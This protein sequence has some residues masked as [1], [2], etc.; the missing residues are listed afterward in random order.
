MQRA[1]QFAALYVK[2]GV[3]GADIVLI[4]LDHGI[5]AHAA[6]VGTM[7]MGAVP[8]FMPSPSVKQDAALYWRQHRDVFGHAQPRAILVSDALAGPVSDA[9]EGTGAAILPVSAV[10]GEAPAEIGELP[11]E[12]AVALLQHSSGTTG[13]KKGVKLSYRAIVAQLDAYRRA[14]NLD[15]VREP[16]IASWL[17]L[18]HDMGLISSFM[19]PLWQG[20]PIL[21]IDP[22]EWTR[23]P[24]LL[25]EAIQDFAGTHAWVPNFALRHHVKSAR[26]REKYDLRSLVAIICC[27]EPNKPEAFDAFYERFAE[28]G[29][30]ETSLQ[31][32]YAMAETVFAMS[33]S[34]AGEKVRRLAVDRDALAVHGVVK[35]PE[36][37]A[38]TTTLLSN[39]KPIDGCEI[40]I[41]QDDAFVGERIVGEVCVT[42]P[43]LFSGY[44][45]NPALSEQAF[46]GKWL[47]TGD[48]GFLDHGE[49]FIVGRL[50]DVII[51]NGKN[52]FAHDV[53]AAV[54]RVAG[55]KP[56]R[57]VAFGHFVEA[58][59]SEQLVVVA[60]SDGAEADAAVIQGGINRAVSQDVGVTCGDVR[61]VAP[62]WLVKTTSGKV[63]R[64]E[65][66]RKYVQMTSEHITP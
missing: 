5:D 7:L 3:R 20:F 49:V 6:F 24:A 16:R 42:A 34:A 43:Y 33:Q 44:H 37:G 14:L 57:A 59:G 29:V 48:L 31:S 15:A 28:W 64:S 30:K 26:A 36:V 46:F 56:G 22:F 58:L 4:I 41:L 35:A 27:S 12:E 39:G 54:S 61:L 25:F 63:S 32:C 1:L 62:G 55:V 18:Y 66:L 60:E 53:E 17:P 13:L 45:R 8:G 10:D 9:A 23:R 47:R 38:E 11:A 40:G 50:K 21:S 19:L 51:I 52:V 2:H 65:N